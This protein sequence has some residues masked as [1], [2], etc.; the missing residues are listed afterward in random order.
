MPQ[1]PI[2]Q[3]GD[4]RLDTAS[5]RTLFLETIGKLVGAKYAENPSENRLAQVQAVRVPLQS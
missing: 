2:S 3:A 1:A 5:E 4:F